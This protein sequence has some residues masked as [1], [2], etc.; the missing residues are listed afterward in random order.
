MY[1]C[2]FV[3][4]KIGIIY[5]VC[6]I[7]LSALCAYGIS[8]Y[9]NSLQFAMLQLNDLP[10]SYRVL[11]KMSSGITALAPLMISAFLYFTSEL[12]FNSFF[13]EHISKRSLISIIGISYTPM[14]IYQYVFWFNLIL[15]C[16]VGEITSIEEFVNM[17]YILGLCLQDFQF[18]NL[19]C[20]GI[21]YLI[22]IL[23]YI[24][25]DINVFKVLFSMLF[26]SFIVIL[27]YYLF[28]V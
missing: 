21:I 10:F 24:F 1:Q 27:V 2:Q 28:L 25:K 3:N 7:A 26:P 5:S 12:M 22:I 13:E 23:F 18:I 11:F 20:W 4:N 9:C 19:V 16:K 17:K 14:L 15:Y 6:V 8:E